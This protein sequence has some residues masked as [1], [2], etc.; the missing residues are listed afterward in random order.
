[1]AEVIFFIAAIGALAGAIGVVTL[2]NPF[3]SVLALVGHLISLAALFLL[4]RAEFLAAAQVIVYAGA[5]TVLYVFVVS[6]VGDGTVPLGRG[7]ARLRVI[8]GLF[9]GMLFVELCIAML[10]SGL[11]AIDGDGAPYVPGFGSPADIGEALLTKFQLPFQIASLLL[12]TATVG[13]VMLA[14]RRD[15]GRALDDRPYVPGQYIT[16]RSLFSGTLAEAVGRMRA[17]PEE[18]RQ[19]APVP[20]AAPAPRD[21]ANPASGDDAGEEA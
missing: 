10:G 19:P 15:G 8:A 4:L 20:A 18:P 3:Y 1:M 12:L 14:R 9:I 11:K 6:Y 13:A 5:V 16:P 21:G 2:H 7:G 17:P